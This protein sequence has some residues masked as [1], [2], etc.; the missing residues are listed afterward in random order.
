MKLFLI[1]NK[2]IQLGKALNAAAHMAFGLSHR[3]SGGIPSI[4]IYFGDLQ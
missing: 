3:I 4:D 1:L 2:E